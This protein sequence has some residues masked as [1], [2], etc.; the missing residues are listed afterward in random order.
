MKFSK[1]GIFD[2]EKKPTQRI[3]VQ[4]DIRLDPTIEGIM[5]GRDE[6]V[7]RAVELIKDGY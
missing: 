2:P 4:P 7:E 1:I 5:E 6:Y 3:G